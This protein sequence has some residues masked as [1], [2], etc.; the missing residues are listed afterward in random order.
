MAYR[1]NTEGAMQAGTLKVHVC[2]D[3]NA[4]KQNEKMNQWRPIVDELTAAR[5]S[6]SVHAISSKNKQLNN[7]NIRENS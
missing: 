7:R 1:I 6:D 2:L 4:L 3:M 5:K